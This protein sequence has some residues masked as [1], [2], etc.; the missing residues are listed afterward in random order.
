M[1]ESACLRV[2]Y[3][4]F[5]FV[6]AKMGKVAHVSIEVMP[7]Y[8]KKALFIYEKTSIKHMGEI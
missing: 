2:K 3:S 6:T 8:S 1:L 4:M 5:T 7:L